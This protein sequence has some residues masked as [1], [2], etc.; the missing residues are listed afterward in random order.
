VVVRYFGGTKLGASGLINAYK[1]SAQ[2]ALAA[3]TVI[4]K[5]VEDIYQI[6]FDYALMSD[7]M[8]TV[9]KLELDVL[10]QDFG[11]EGIIQFALRQ[12]EVKEKLR[13]LRAGVAKVRIEEIDAIEE[14][15]GFELSFLYTR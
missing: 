4:E 10:K 12:S 14:I 1:T 9:K 11:N 7:V 3:A 13:H 15:E 6:R 5:L 2:E 8:N